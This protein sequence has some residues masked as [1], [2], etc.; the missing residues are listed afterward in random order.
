MT[1]EEYRDYTRRLRERAPELFPPGPATWRTEASAIPPE[2]ELPG[3][4]YAL[5]SSG[6]QV[7]PEKANA[8][9]TDTRGD[10]RPKHDILTRSESGKAAP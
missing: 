2:F 1:D 5:D 3:S 8:P 10:H 7:S 9:G 6:P 4:A